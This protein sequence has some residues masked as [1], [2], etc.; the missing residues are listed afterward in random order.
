MHVQREYSGRGIGGCGHVR[1]A[2][3]MAKRKHFLKQWRKH[4]G[5]SQV[6]LA[7]RLHITQGHLSKIENYKSPWDEHLLTAAA[8]ELRCEVV[9]LLIRDPS[10]PDS[11]WSIWDQLKPVEQQQVVEVAKVLRKTGTEG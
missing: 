10:Q 11:I 4:R 6:Q 3:R 7:E 2:L 8:D 1:D 9:D 5:Y